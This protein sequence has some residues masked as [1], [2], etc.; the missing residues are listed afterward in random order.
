MPKLFFKQFVYFKNQNLRN[1]RELFDQ[2]R[3]IAQLKKFSVTQ[4]LVL[5]ISKTD[6]HTKQKEWDRAEK[7]N[8]GEGDGTR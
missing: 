1:F 3:L 8:E 7:D 5:Q 2:V 6:F 4:Y